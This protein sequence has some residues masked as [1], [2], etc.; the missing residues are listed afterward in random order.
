M[1]ALLMASTCK[2][3]SI[4]FAPFYSLGDVGDVVWSSA[5]SNKQ[6]DVISKKR[7]PSPPLLPSSS[8]RKWCF[9]DDCNLCRN[10]P[11][12]SYRVFRWLGQSAQTPP[13]YSPIREDRKHESRTET[14]PNSCT[15]FFIGLLHQMQS[16][17]RFKSSQWA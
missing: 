9:M 16:N 10:V 3:D 13:P 1:I 4:S 11:S 5:P 15:R 8:L 14:R 17:R 12:C 7:S 2:Q 6:R